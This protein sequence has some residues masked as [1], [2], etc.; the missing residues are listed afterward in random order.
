MDAWRQVLDE[1]RA[2]VDL[3]GQRSRVGRTRS[4]GL[5]TVAF[6]YGAVP[7]EGIEQNPEKSSRW[8]QLAR[9]G[10]RIM[11]FRANRRYIANV[12]DGTLTRYSGWAAAGLPE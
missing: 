9:D 10:K 4:Q 5:R 6:L 1:G 12:C 8:A 7:I 11:Q 3:A 2:E